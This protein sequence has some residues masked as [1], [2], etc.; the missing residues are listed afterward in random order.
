MIKLYRQFKKQQVPLIA[1]GKSISFKQKQISFR[2]VHM[3]SRQE[4][5][6]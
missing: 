2:D 3:K 6:V 5:K 4:T 1:A